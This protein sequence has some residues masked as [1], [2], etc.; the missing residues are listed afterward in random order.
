MG[1]SGLQ[2][3]P[4]ELADF[5]QRMMCTAQQ[6]TSN[7]DGSRELVQACARWSTQAEASPAFLDAAVAGGIRWAIYD[8]LCACAAMPYDLCDSQAFRETGESVP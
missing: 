8:D 4:E 6:R 2:G 3:S 1:V 7:A 5:T